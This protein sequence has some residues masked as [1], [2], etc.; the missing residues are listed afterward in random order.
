MSFFKFFFVFLMKID[1][2]VIAAART[3]LKVKTYNLEK[4][5]SKWM[6][7]WSFYKIYFNNFLAF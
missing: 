6:K 5:E 1:E 4:F 3:Q 2:N 7:V